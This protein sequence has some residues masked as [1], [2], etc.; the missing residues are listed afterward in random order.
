M[1]HRKE[2]ADIVL[3]INV[4]I[5]IAFGLAMVSFLLIL[6][7]LFFTGHLRP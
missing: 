5:A 7:L 3:D 1:K 4:R 2:K 6:N